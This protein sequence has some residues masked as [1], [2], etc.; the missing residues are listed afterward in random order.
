M[1]PKNPYSDAHVRL[2]R[3]YEERVPEGMTQKAFGA[4]YGIGTQSMVA[5]YIT[6]I[7]PLNYD[8]AAKFAKGLRCTIYDISPEMADTLKDE[9]L[10]VLGRALRRAAALACFA[11]A[12]ALLPS[13]ADASPH[14]FA[15]AAACVL[16]QIHRWLLE[17]ARSIKIS[18]RESCAFTHTLNPFRPSF[19]LSISPM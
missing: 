16:C 3:L 1:K 10:P 17:A 2:K 15:R 7:K 19:H 9:I 11:I 8:A 6:G 18:L 13:P 12:P 4:A 14:F 5:Q